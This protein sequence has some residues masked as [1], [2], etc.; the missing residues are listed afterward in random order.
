MASQIFMLIELQ[1]KWNENKLMDK[2]VT[3]VTKGIIEFLFIIIPNSKCLFRKKCTVL[4]KRNATPLYFNISELI[5]KIEFYN[6][7]LFYS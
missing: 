6:Y 5:N 3:K 1:V 7:L 2:E 4:V